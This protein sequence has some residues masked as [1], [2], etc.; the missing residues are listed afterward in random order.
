MTEEIK[1]KMPVKNIS[2]QLLSCNFDKI[3]KDSLN[4]HFKQTYASIESIFGVV[5]PE[6]KRNGILFSCA[7][8][9]S[10]LDVLIMTLEHIESGT[11]KSTPIK[12]LNTSDMQKWGASLTYAT[13][14]GIMLMLGLTAGIE[15]EMDGNDTLD[16]KKIQS[17]Q[18][19]LQPQY[20]SRPVID[21]KQFKKDLLE[22]WNL[23]KDVALA[24][25]KDRAVRVNDFAMHNFMKLNEDETLMELPVDMLVSIQK[26]LKEL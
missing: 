22:L 2:T 24:I 6:L 25:D 9:P 26:W 10:A 5:M 12:L 17:S 15:P 16:E 8:D 11:S 23:K 3:E 20:Q 7:M 19:K 18:S 1:E 4:T 14:R 21:V 13:R